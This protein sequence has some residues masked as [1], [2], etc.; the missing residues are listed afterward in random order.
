MKAGLFFLG[1]VTL[2]LFS[3]PSQAVVCANI[4]D[5]ATTVTF[6]LDSALSSGSNAV[7]EIISVSKS[8]IGTV[9]AVCPKTGTSSIRSYRS[10]RS[11]LAVAETLSSFKYM[12]INDYLEAAMSITDSSA[13]TFYPPVDYVQM[14][15]S[16]DVA[17]GNEFQIKD[18]SL[19][20]KLKILKNI[21]GAVVIPDTRLFTVYVTTATTDSLSTPVYY[22]DLEGLIEIPESCEINA[23]NTIDI[24]FGTVIS[25]AFAEAGAGNRPDDVAVKNVSVAIACSNVATSATLTLRVE[26]DR[27]SGNAILANS[28]DDIGFILSDSNNAVL[29][30]ND[31][32]STTRFSL[33][34]NGDAS[35]S[36]KAWPISV[37]GNVPEPGEYQATGYLRVDYE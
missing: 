32:S 35:V 13:G 27:T 22:I 20:L 12:K 1:I 16:K 30:P 8:S 6:D 15:G 5:S 21:V 19:V 14:G 7:G 28:S 23:G 36:I 11:D 4:S 9:T 25:T 17:Q 33:N 37:T 34:S 10:Y 29:T 2:A 24:D 3:Q 18:S 26:A 31:A